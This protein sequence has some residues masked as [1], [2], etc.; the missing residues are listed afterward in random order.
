MMEQ[1]FTRKLLRP[2]EINL[3]INIDETTILLTDKLSL[4]NYYKT[5][6][7]SGILS[8][9]EVRN[10]LEL[11]DIDGGDEHYLPYTDLS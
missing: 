9:N 4:A 2:S 1:E 11:G 6:I 3:S 10:D 5:M 7:S 8:I